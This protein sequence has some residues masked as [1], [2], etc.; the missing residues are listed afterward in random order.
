MAR[1]FRKPTEDSRST[2]ALLIGLT[3]AFIGLFLLLPLVMVFSAALQQG[4]A[5]ALSALSE[6]DAV[7]AIELS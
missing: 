2:R 6:P 4:L 5:G 1:R 3:L 7:S